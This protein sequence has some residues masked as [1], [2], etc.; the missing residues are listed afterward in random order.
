MIG[1]FKLRAER[2]EVQGCIPGKVGNFSLLLSER[3][4]AHPA[5]YKICTVECLPRIRQ[6]A[7]FSFPLNVEG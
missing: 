7:A 6:D 2:L 3:F 1:L 5:F 4:K